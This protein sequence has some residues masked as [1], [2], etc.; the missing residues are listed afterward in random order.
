MI[1]SD[2]VVVMTGIGAG[3]GAKLSARIAAEGG[4][5]VMVSR[6][7]DVMESVQKE[8]EAAGGEALCVPANVVKEEECARVAAVA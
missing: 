4:R 5:V 1:L 7:T 2:E 8:I 6:S 3:M